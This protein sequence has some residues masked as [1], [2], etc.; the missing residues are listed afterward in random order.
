MILKRDRHYYAVEVT[1]SD[2]IKI[3]STPVTLT[4]GIYWTH[5]DTA[6]VADYP[7]I[8]QMICSRLATV[9]GGS[10]TVEP[11]TPAN[12]LLRSGVRL[13]KI[14]GSAPTLIDFSETTPL[15]QRVLGFSG[16]ENGTVSFD[17]SILN[18]EYSAYGSWSPWS[19]F[20][21]RAESKDSYM[22]RVT[23]WSST[24]PE[25][26]QVV[27]WRERRE[28]ILSYPY[29]YGCYINQNRA[30]YASYAGR[31]GL[32][33][34]D[35]NNSLENLWMN[36]GRNLSDIIVVYDLDDLD[37]RVDEYEY[38]IVRFSDVRS[39]QSVSNLATRAMLGA[40][41]WNVRIPYVVIGGSYGL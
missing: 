41:V 7:S 17:G 33:E 9:Y 6:I 3:D 35:K 37:L 4:P 26:A 16:S 1:S 31:A 25:V 36:A 39:C 20:E 23:N 12:T 8:Y 19:F 38:E 21:G 29:V 40:D 30:E 13:R 32:Q 22:D 15:I 18:G 24:H 27:I 14:G 28:R 5:F 34:G 11:H 10:W 2:R